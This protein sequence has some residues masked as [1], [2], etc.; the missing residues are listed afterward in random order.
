MR[1]PRSF[2]FRFAATYRLPAL[3]FGVTS[4]TAGVWVDEAAL[5]I[6]FGPWRVQTPLSNVATT[7]HTG[8]YSLIKTMGPAHLSFADRGLTCATNSE[9]GLCI[10]FV[11]PVPGIEPLGLL[12]HPAVTVT[13]ADCDGLAE[14]LNR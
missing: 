1:G 5:R 8:P 2:P 4:N 12:R 14:V 11:R 7:L 10:R 9:R 3:L 6:R 13:V